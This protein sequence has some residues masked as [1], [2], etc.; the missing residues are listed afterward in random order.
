MSHSLGIWS[1]MRDGRDQKYEP[2]GHIASRV[3]EL[4]IFIPSKT[5]AHIMELHIFRVDFSIHPNLETPSQKCLEICSL[6]YL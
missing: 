1:I 5:P 2:T 6:P 4:V 3:R